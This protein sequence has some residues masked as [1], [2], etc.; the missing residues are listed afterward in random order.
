[1]WL[2]T[3][4]QRLLLLLP[5]LTIAATVSAVATATKR[6]SGKR[7]VRPASV[8]SIRACTLFWPCKIKL[9][10]SVNVSANRYFAS[11]LF[12][13]LWSS[14][15]S[16]QLRIC[17]VAALVTGNV[18]STTTDTRRTLHGTVCSGWSQPSDGKPLPLTSKLSKCYF[19]HC[20]GYENM[21]YVLV[22][23]HYD[24]WSTRRCSS[25]IP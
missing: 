19:P 16:K 3:W 7:R 18:C 23:K 14:S 21:T 24:H 5:L 9:R 1:M 17:F 15:F 8:A 13:K 10:S 6:W 11:L 4:W 25:S 2:I 12:I 22:W 20:H